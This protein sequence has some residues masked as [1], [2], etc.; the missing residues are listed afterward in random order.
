[1]YIYIY[2]DFLLYIY[3]YIYM[4]CGVQYNGV[5]MPRPSIGMSKGNL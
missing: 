5:N 4:E 2:I 3:I 1:M